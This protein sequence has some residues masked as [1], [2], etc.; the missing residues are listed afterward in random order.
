MELRASHE[1]MIGAVLEKARR[2][3]PDGLDLVGV[4]G[5]AATGIGAL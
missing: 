5:S 3:C 4:Y 1:K 2:C